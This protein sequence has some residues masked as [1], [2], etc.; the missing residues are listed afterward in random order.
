[1]NENFVPGQNVTQKR[2]WF[3]P[4]ILGWVGGSIS[5]T[6][7]IFTIYIFGDFS[8]LIALL[9]PQYPEYPSRPLSETETVTPA[10]LTRNPILVPKSLAG[11]EY[12]LGINTVVTSVNDITSLNNESLTPLLRNI[13]TAYKEKRFVDTISLFIQGRSLNKK[14]KEYITA[15]SVGIT[16]LRD[17]NNSVKDATLSSLTKEFLN[18]ATVLHDNALAYADIVDVFLSGQVP[19]QGTFLKLGDIT[20]IITEHAPAFDIAAKNLLGYLGE[21]TNDTVRDNK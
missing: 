17:G 16:Q 6:I 3:L 15:L 19:S 14:Q 20:K 21:K 2:K 8:S 1:M 13:E 5:T 11:E 9:P 12:Y 18:E 7:I 10:P 4:G